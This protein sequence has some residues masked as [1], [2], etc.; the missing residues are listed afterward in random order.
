MLEK[1]KQN[2]EEYDIVP[3]YDLKWDKDLLQNL[4]IPSSMAPDALSSD[5]VF[6][7]TEAGDLFNR[8]IPITGVMGD[9]HAALF[10]Q[11]CFEPGMGKAT[12]GTGSSIMMNIGEQPQKSPQ[13]L[14]TSIGWGRNN[15]V[16][17]IFEG[18][19]H[20]TGDTINWLVKDLKLLDNPVES[21]KLALSVPDN[22]GVYLVPAF[23]GLGAP[24]WENRARASISGMPRSTQK[25]HIA[26]A[27]LE[28]IAYQVRDLIDLMTQN[29]EAILK[30]LRVDGGPTRNTFLMQFLADMVNS[31][32]VRTQ[33]EEV[34]SL[35]VAFMAGL[36]LGIWKDLNELQALRQVDREFT[37]DMDVSQRKLLYKGWQSAVQSVL[38]TA[39]L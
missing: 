20:C 37:P 30:E 12:F 18:N 27:A 17:Y 34:S 3:C 22:N 35:G 29:T 5:A 32:I 6:G 7:Y 21:E 9:S 26:R 10:G 36:T 24:Y 8:E 13:G 31:K 15:G 23:A 11:N 38:N 14:V 4:N 16:N 25:A 33:A 19:I 28:A 1:I 2:I 39:K